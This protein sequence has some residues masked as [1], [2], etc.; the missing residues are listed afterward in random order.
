MKSAFERTW[1]RPK[2]W[3]SSCAISCAKNCADERPVRKTKAMSLRFV[4]AQSS[5]G[6]LTGRVTDETGAALP[7]VTVT[8]TNDATGFHRSDVTGADGTYRFGSVPI[9]IYTVVADL[10]GF[11]VVTT[12]NVQVADR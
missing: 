10:S 8:A 6:N 4:F 3:P 9:G 1:A 11:N 12:K 5:G 2:E 7:G